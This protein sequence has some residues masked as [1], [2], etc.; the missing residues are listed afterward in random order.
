[1]G[2]S[3]GAGATVAAGDYAVIAQD[4]AA[5]ASAYGIAAYGPFTGKLA[6]EGERIAMRDAKGDIEEEVE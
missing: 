2:S 6:N 1:M 3:C 5:L 4:P